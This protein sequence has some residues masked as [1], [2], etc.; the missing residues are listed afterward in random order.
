MDEAAE[1]EAEADEDEAEADED[2]AAEAVATTVIVLTS[3]T[4]TLTAVGYI[5]NVFS[6][7]P[8]QTSTHGKQSIW[9][10]INLYQDIILIPMLGT[11]LG[12]DFHFYI[13]EFELVSFDFEFLKFMEFPVLESGPSIIDELDY[14]QPDELF[15]D[16]QIESGSAF[17][18]HFQF[19]KAM[20]I[21]LLLNMT[22][23][24]FR[25][26]VNK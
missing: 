17:V 16:N 20:F 15:A 24:L 3:L 7:S 22:F 4:A 19:I 23:I 9:A 14:E 25:I 21:T 8:S 18:N 6:A 5:S 13:T 10:Q 26:V 11:Y 1:A 12:N 2:E